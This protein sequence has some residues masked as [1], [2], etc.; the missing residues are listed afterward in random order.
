MCADGTTGLA[1]A[2]VP[3]R[4]IGTRA[5][6]KSMAQLQPFAQAIEH[7]VFV[8]VPAFSWIV[9][10]PRRAVDPTGPRSGRATLPGRSAP[11]AGRLR[12]DPSYRPDSPRFREAAAS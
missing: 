7:A 3:A 12:N 11:R 8:L 5:S 1:M 9:P 6:L 4:N 10:R 2:A